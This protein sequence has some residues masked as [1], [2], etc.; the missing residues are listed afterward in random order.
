MIAKCAQHSA[1]FLVSACWGCWWGWR[2]FF[3]WCC[4]G[5]EK[6]LLRSSERYRDLASRE[7]AQRVTTYLDEAPMAVTHF[8]QQVKYGLIDPRKT[9]SVEQGLLSLLLANDN[10]SEATLTYANSKGDGR[11]GNIVIDQASAGQVAVLRSTTVGE[12]IRKKTW[13]NGTQFVSQSVTLRAEPAAQATST[14]PVVP[15]VDPTA[16]PTFQTA[17][18]DRLRTDYLDGS[19]L[20]PA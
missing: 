6:T 9:D 2:C 8:E 18:Y 15:S 3:I 11:A 1:R 19:A 10:I 14:A 12:F 13:F 7:V 20:V 17:V 16:H 4:N 5:L